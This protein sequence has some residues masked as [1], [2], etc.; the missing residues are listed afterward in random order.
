LAPGS[1][2]ELHD[3]LDRHGGRERQRA[4]AGQEP[5]QQNLS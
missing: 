4:A 1:R 2:F 3:R 5:I